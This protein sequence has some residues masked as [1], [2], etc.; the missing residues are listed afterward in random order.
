MVADV[1]EKN[2]WEFQAKSGSSGSC[3]LFPSFPRKI[4]VRKMSGKAPGSPRHPSSRHPSSRHPWP[5]DFQLFVSFSRISWWTFRSRK[6]IWPPPPPPKKIPQFAA[7]TLPAN[8]P[9]PQEPPPLLGFQLKKPSPPPPSLSLRTPPS[10]S[11]SRKNK[12]IR[13]VHQVEFLLG[14]R[15]VENPWCFGWFSLVFT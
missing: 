13:N 14:S 5:S 2:V 3:Q 8:R 15:G 6:N 11:R 4:A 1:W 12:N 9:S 10:P 7:D